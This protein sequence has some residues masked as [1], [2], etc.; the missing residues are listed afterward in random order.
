MLLVALIELQ[1]FARH[2]LVGSKWVVVSFLDPYK[3]KE[4]I[5]TPNFEWFGLCPLQ[6]EDNG[7][8][9]KV[10]R[11]SEKSKPF[12]L[13]EFQWKNEFKWQLTMNKFIL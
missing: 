5:E 13:R 6:Q 12:D 1:N 7:K 11:W 4:Q 2:I 8:I 3:E 10:T 9:Q